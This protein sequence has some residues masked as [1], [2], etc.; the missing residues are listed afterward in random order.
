MASGN[1]QPVAS[2]VAPLLM[3]AAAP[4]APDPGPAMPDSFEAVVELFGERREALLRTHLRNHVHLASFEPGRIVVT[5]TPEAPAN[6]A[7]TVGKLL[8]EWTDKPS[9]IEISTEESPEPT[10]RG[11]A[12][13][14]ARVDREEAV[15]DPV[16]QAALEAF[17]GSEVEDV[18][19]VEP[20]FD[21]EVLEPEPNDGDEAI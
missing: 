12:D 7:A 3:N 4:P 19:Q 16:V 6:L 5:T 2:R 20:A 15:R 17:P 14:S 9:T 11:Q 21:G 10:L 8:R 18:R 13:E 1:P